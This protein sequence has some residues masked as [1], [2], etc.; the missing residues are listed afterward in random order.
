MIEKLP[1]FNLGR[2]QMLTSNFRPASSPNFC[3]C[4]FH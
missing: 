1:G 3:L 4:F 2:L